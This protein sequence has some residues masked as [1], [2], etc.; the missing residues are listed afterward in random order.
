MKWKKTILITSSGAI[1]VIGFMWWI[2]LQ[3]F[4]Q[5]EGE[6]HLPG[7]TGKVTV[8]FDRFANPTISA[9]S[10][11]D[12]YFSLGY[13]IARERMFQMD[14][15]RRKISGRLSEVFGKKA[16][17][18]DILHRHLGF[19]RSAAEIVE[20]LPVEQRQLLRAYAGGVN[21]YLKTASILPVEFLAL[22]Y[23]PEPWREEDSILVSLNMF[24]QLNWVEANERMV[25]VMKE[26]LPEDVVAF[27]TPQNDSYSSSVLLQGS[28]KFEDAM[29]RIPVKS[30]QGL[31]TG[32]HKVATGLVDTHSVQAGSN[33]WA[34]NKT[35]DG[36]AILAN[37]MHLHLSVPNIWYQASLQYQDV[38]IKGIILPGMPLVVAGS[39]G[40][41]AWGYT[42][43]QADV[44]DLVILNKQPGDDQLYKT[45]QGW[46]QIETSEEVVKVKDE[47]DHIV[48]V[49]NTVWG[50]VSP[51]LLMGEEVAVQWNAFYPEA[52]NLDLA[53]M[54]R[55]NRM[56]DAL[57]L[58][59]NAGLPVMNVIMADNN[60]NIAWTLTG[61]IPD[62]VG[63]DGST[64]V[65]WANGEKSW[66]GF[67][68]PTAYPRINNPSSGFLMTAN[69]RVL[70]GKH[71]F[72]YGRNFGNSYRAYR[73]AELLEQGEDLSVDTMHRMQLD[74]KTNFYR[75]YQHL[76]LSVLSR[77]GSKLDSYL[78]NIRNA[79]ESWDGF[80]DAKSTGFG[81]LVEFRRRLADTIFSSYIQECKRQDANFR[82]Q[83]FEMDTPLRALLSQQIPESLPDHLHY[84]SWNDLILDAL[85]QVAE[86]LEVRF[87]G[88]N[89]EQLE[90]GQMEIF[91][92]KHPFS[93]AYSWLG[94]FLDLP[95]QPLSGCVHCVRVSKRDFAA[96]MR[97]VVSPGHEDEMILVEPTGQSGHPFSRH[98]KDKFF[99]WVN[100]ITMK[101]DDG[102]SDDT[103]TLLPEK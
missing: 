63:F 98:Y 13:L 2:V 39:N 64:S 35:S 61:R 68:S 21:S 11:L 10:K 86:N 49:R 66:A 76:L 5:T 46:K 100:G 26:S 7:L 51:R 62:R 34:V 38:S 45:E 59:N 60:G 36:R 17:N 75:F 56:E 74:T 23:S 1:L 50:P 84:D 9:D 103:L 4:P 83:W 14:M 77:E 93:R 70:P 41:I 44:L 32:N 48:V 43:S 30:L 85:A 37:D 91:Q 72:K 12:A 81:I 54:D 96:S 57:T 67:V 20:A 18:N 42:N 88:V 28:E 22:G 97:M 19:S 27:L 6:M 55:T 79:V 99:Y 31:V 71:P 94:Y 90:W 102:G 29:T 87:P 16:L 58:F 69:N 65:S 89:P 92:L 3:T 52:V 47:E 8:R 25:S 78:D 82:Y 101:E 80:A 53:K 15:M 95:E 33:Q 24:H 40:H 73:I